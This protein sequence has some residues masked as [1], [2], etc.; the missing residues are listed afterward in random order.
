MTKFWRSKSL[1]KLTVLLCI[2]VSM[3]L[4]SAALAAELDLSKFMPVDEI[5]PGMKGIGKTVFQ[6]TRIDEFQIEILDVSSDP[7]RLGDIIWV[8]CSGGPLAETGVLGGMSGSP[9]YIDGRLIGALAYRS[10]VFSKQPIA[11]VTPIASMLDILEKADSDT[12]HS[13]LDTRY[14]DE[15]FTLLAYEAE[16]GMGDPESRIQDS[17]TSVKPIQAPLMVS[18]FHPRTIADMAPV[19]KKLGMIPIQG[20][21]ASSRDTA[22]EVPLE[23]GAV[24]GV[25]FVRGDASSFGYGTVTYVQD[26]KVLGFGHAMLSVGNTNLPVVGGRVAFLESSLQASS[27]SAISGKAVGT[28]IYD[29]E[30]GIMGIVGR[31]PEFIPMKVKINSREYNFEIAENRIFSPMYVRMMV[32]STIY[33]TGKSL[34]P[35]TMR[36]H[37]EIKLKGYPTISKDDIFSGRSPG[38]VA[39]ALAMP[40][41]SLMQSKFEEVD[42]ESI[43]FEMSFEDRRVN[44]LIDEIRINKERV[45]PGD[46]V[47]ATVFLTPYMEDTVTKQIEVAIPKDIPEGPAFLII[48]DAK[49][50]SSWETSRAP[51]KTKIVDMAH[52]IQRIQEEENNSDLIVELFVSKMGVT[53]RNQELPALPLTTFSVMNS[54]KHAGGSGVTRGTT[55]LK[56]RVSTDYVIAGSAM[57]FLIIDRDAP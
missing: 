36:T 35:Y 13:M 47:T 1:G 51:L 11:G 21:G 52:I 31:E 42:V 46:S 5:K 10:G 22:V 48:A 38:V 28:L 18:G 40:M 50:S 24:I 25:Q 37:S 39:S 6:G 8:M 7:Y 19:F 29:S 23:P 44:A 9:I 49:F 16:P 56:K 14:I 17:V 45:R 57:M 20:G 26:D 34:G 33:S 43:L 32:S 3:C 55:F 27:K 53:I 2:F 54:R 4:C 30:Y 41:Y 15:T 12:Q